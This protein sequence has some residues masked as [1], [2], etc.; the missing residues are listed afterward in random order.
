MKNRKL[1]QIGWLC[2]L[3]LVTFAVAPV[4]APAQENPE[5]KN[6]AE[7]LAQHDEALGR[8]DV[9][10][11]MSLY[12]DGNNTVMMG[13]GPGERW[14]GKAEIRGAFDQI[15]KDYDSGSQTRD[16]YWRTGGVNGNM[17]WVSAMCKMGD[18]LKKKKRSYELNISAVFEKVSD[19]WLV[20]SMHY[21]NVVGGA[22]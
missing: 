2:G 3:L 6:L 12:A 4:R 15:V 8:K 10:A 14:Q 22:K 7:L 21:S 16:C 9:D 11:L 13:T 18:S 17:A 19:K 1:I 20:R 5:V